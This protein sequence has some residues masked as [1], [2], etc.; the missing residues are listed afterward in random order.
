[1]ADPKHNET[2]IDLKE[3]FTAQDWM[4]FYPDA[5]ENISLDA[6]TEG[7]RGPSELLCGYRSHGRSSNPP[8]PF[9]D[10]IVFKQ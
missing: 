7:K 1:M 6:K 8:I 5:I 4:D 3:K 2:M 9:W 10:H